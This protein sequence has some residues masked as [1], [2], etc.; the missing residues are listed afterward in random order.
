MSGET[1]PYVAVPVGTSYMRF[2]AAGAA[3]CSTRI[4]ARTDDS[5][6][7]FSAESGARYTVHVDRAG[8]SYSSISVDP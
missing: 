2:V 4:D 8:W 1:T 7:P 3:D 5:I 6:G